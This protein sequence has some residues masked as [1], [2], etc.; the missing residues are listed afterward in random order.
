MVI[1]IEHTYLVSSAVRRTLAYAFGQFYLSFLYFALLDAP[2]SLIEVLENTRNG[3][4]NR[5]TITELNKWK[6]QAI[7]HTLER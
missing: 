2:L 5:K 7:M 3:K 1:L 6:C 4:T